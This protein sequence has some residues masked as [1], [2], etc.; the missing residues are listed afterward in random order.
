MNILK[1]YSYIGKTPQPLKHLWQMM[2]VN[3]YWRNG[4]VINNAISGVDMALWILKPN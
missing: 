4:P 2:M 3:A 1:T